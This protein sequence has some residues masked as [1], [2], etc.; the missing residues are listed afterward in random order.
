MPRLINCISV[1]VG[2][3]TER[4]RFKKTPVS[5]HLSRMP[6]VV[7]VFRPQGSWRIGTPTAPP[8]SQWTDFGDPSGRPFAF[9]H[10]SS[11]KTLHQ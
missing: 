7:D 1:T 5:V 11:E 4:A 8:G 6:S 9:L 10:L 2:L 3:N